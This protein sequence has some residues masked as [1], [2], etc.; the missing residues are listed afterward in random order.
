MLRH[1]QSGLGRWHRRP[2]PLYPWRLCVTLHPPY[3]VWKRQAGPFEPPK[4]AR[5]KSSQNPNPHPLR[6]TGLARGVSLCVTAE[7]VEI[8]ASEILH[9]PLL[10]STSATS[11]IMD[12]RGGPPIKRARDAPFSVCEFGRVGSSRT[13][14]RLPRDSCRRCRPAR[15]RAEGNPKHS[16][17]VV[18]KPQCSMILVST[19][20]GSGSPKTCKDSAMAG[21]DWPRL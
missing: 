20:G 2:S 17:L 7:W 15:A 9:V 13:N 6:L 5:A 3:S 19:G 1:W 4:S 18:F 14:P 8:I 21:F 11:V 16:V 12:C 10:R